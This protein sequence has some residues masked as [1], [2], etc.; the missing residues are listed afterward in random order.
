MG[1]VGQSG[2][3]V[4]FRTQPGNNEDYSDITY[5]STDNRMEC[6]I[7]GSQWFMVKDSYTIDDGNLNPNTTGYNNGGTADMIIFLCH[8]GH[9]FGKDIAL[10]ETW[11]AQADGT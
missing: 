8:N 2:K 1:Y 6:P 3:Y 4:G 5:S 9:E 11:S 7:C 10:G